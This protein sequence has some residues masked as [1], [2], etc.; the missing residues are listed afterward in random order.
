MPIVEAIVGIPVLGINNTDPTR[1]IDIRQA[2]VLRNM[3][4]VGMAMESVRGWRNSLGSVSFNRLAVAQTDDAVVYRKKDGTIQYLFAHG[5][6]VYAAPSLYG[7]P[8]DI[9][10]VGTATARIQ[11]VQFRE[12]VFI[13]N[14][15]DANKKYDGVHV[16]NMGIA[17][18]TVAATLQ[19]VGGATP[20]N[21]D[22]YYTWYNS[23]DETES[24][25]SAKST[26]ATGTSPTIRVKGSSDL[27][28]DKVRL[29]RTG[30]GITVP[31]LA[32]EIANPGDVDLDI[33]DDTADSTVAQGEA[34]R[35]DRTKPPVLSY[36]ILHNNRLFC[37]GDPD[38]PDTIWVSGEG[39]P[40]YMPI[41]PML[42]KADAISGGPIEVRAGD[43][44]DLVG[45]ASWGGMLI[46]FK[47]QNAYRIMESEVGFYSYQAMPIHGCIAR[48]SVQMTAAGLV[49]L[50]AHGWMLLDSNETQVAIGDPIRA[51]SD[52][53]I[54]PESV[55]SGLSNGVYV[56]SFSVFGETERK[57]LT[58]VPAQGWQG[59]H[60][61]PFSS[62]YEDVDGRL[63]CGRTDQAGIALYNS[64]ATGLRPG[65]EI[66]DMPVDVEWADGAR[67]YGA[68]GRYKR[69]LKAR[70]Y[71]RVL[72]TSRRT[73]TLYFEVLDDTGTL[74]SSTAF[75]LGIDG[76]A[77]VGVDSAA[78]AEFLQWRIRGTVN[79]PIQIHRVLPK[80]EIGATV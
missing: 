60:D 19:A 39:E 70:I 15:V 45:L 35:W 51:T 67:D 46:A 8:E 29:Y 73:E 16:W 36:A 21:K 64:W 80:V 59:V 22:Y 20:S 26:L 34:L 43:G 75:S 62:F 7:E 4:P 78:C 74:L 61:L 9:G 27:Q 71:G 54:D 50:T 49:W 32:K 72:A 13:L 76:E 47:S 24:D 25:P 63:Y 69:M 17:A 65:P 2:V 40:Q 12:Q 14:G 42:D 1:E 28:V 11:L 48:R 6:R 3:R 66:Q 23:T 5:G 38:N 55:A 30:S 53:V 33:V 41:L 31:R 79:R 44:Q 56:C 77:E 18:P 68:P 58:Y 37:M 10:Y 52:L 57:G